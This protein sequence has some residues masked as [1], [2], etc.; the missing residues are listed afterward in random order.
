MFLVIINI[1]GGG[2][3]NSVCK[4]AGYK[5][6]LKNFT[7]EELLFW[8]IVDN[9]HRIAAA[10]RVQI[11]EVFWLVQILIGVERYQLNVKWLRLW[12]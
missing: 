2:L 8:V 1:Y 4:V 12:A 11:V 9:Q 10:T 3:T 7:D 6:I 5:L